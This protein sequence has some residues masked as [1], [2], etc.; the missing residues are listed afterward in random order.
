MGFKILDSINSPQDLKRLNQ[1]D[2]KL[3]AKEIRELIVEVVSETG[4]HL[5]TSLGAVEIAIA[6]HYC[7][8]TPADKIVWDV[9]H[10]AYAHKI[11]TGRRGNFK[12]LRQ[13]G[14]LSGFPNIYESE[15]DTFTVGH[16]STSISSALG[17]A[18]ARDLNNESHKVVAVIGDGSLVGGM[19][20]EA[21][22]HAGHRKADL[23]IVLND[24]EM[25][26][27]PSV[28]AFSKYLNRI[29]INPIY[30]KIHNDLA[31][32]IK[33][34]P[35][36]GFRA[37]R[38]ARKLEEGLKNLL[39]PG[40]LFEELGI[41]Y[42]GPIDGH[43][44]EQLIETLRNILTL[45]GPILI[46]TVTKKGKGYIH[47]EKHPERFHGTAPFDVETGEIKKVSSKAEPTFTDTFSDG[48]IELA[49]D[50]KRIVAITAAMPEGT[51]LKKFEE[52]FPDRF[53]NVGMA[54]QHA[55]TFGA[56]LAKGG[57][58]PVVAIYSTFLQRSYDQIMHDVCLQGLH[59]VFCL[60]RAGIVGEDGP[61]H[62]GLFDISY[63]RHIPN[64]IIMAPKDQKE[65]K[66]M[67][68][69]A[70]YDCR[71]PVAIRYPRSKLIAPLGQFEPISYGKAEV[72]A[73]NGD[74]AILAIGSMTWPSYAAA[75]L[76]SKEGIKANVINMRFIKPL[77][78]K[79]LKESS[80]RIKRFVVVEEG[81][82][83]GGLGSA[84]LEFFERENLENVVVKRIGLPNKF[85]EHG[86]RDELLK[87]YGL[88]AQEIAKEVKR[89]F[90]KNIFVKV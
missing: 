51:G 81:V 1:E 74:L 64:I 3:L 20:F 18:L 89:I 86:K 90:F 61:T 88:A 43:N 44:L 83:E 60:D 15:Y 4:G 80:T 67:L 58:I 35:W 17:L 38:A 31:N 70:I 27:A 62:H 48:L 59:V 37:Y 39:I 32:L 34:V 57:L 42:V 69:F 29:I 49:K 5:A 36:Y 41:R 76:L 52:F 11:L 56:G 87:I 10:Q 2:L 54:E 30:N 25:S 6:L 7:L 85:I 84:I 33:R 75:T 47:A 22:N 16:G 8:D 21:L 71:G 53:F 46:H 14:G 26:I 63:L 65:F 13:L 79:L 40:M 9:G 55:V 73:K 19:A 24:N 82:L 23:V 78:V 50:D 72:I 77:D 45:E 28:G 12:T 68:K 66:E